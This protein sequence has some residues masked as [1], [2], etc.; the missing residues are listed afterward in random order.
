ACAALASPPR[1]AEVGAW[2]RAPH[3]SADPA[4]ID[5][6]DPLAAIVYTSGTTGRPKGA[7]LP[8][9]AFA[10]SAAASRAQLGVRAGDRW[11]ACLPLFHVGGLAVL[12]RSAADGVAVELHERFDAAA[13]ASRLASGEVQWASLVPAMLARVLAADTREASPAL[14]GILVGGAAA[15]EPLLE[16]AAKRGFPI[17]PTYGLTE[18]ASQVATRP[19]GAPGRG[20]VPLPATQVAIADDG[21]ILVA[22][23]TVMRG[24]WRQPG[25]TERALRGGW[26]HTG[27]VGR[28]DERGA[29]HVLARRTDLIVSGGENVYPAEVEAVLAEHPSVREVAVAGV[30]DAEFGARPAA[31]IVAA[32]PLDADGLR[33]FCRARLAGYKVPVAFHRVAALPRGASGKVLRDRLR[34][35]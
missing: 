29:L 27:D 1:R 4:R 17:A 25:A 5:D 2:L 13:V 31:W 3:A 24:Y 26:L 18:A 33:A 8:A 7:M 10:A 34:A 14:R 15:P 12:A 23:P 9:R 11:L 32:A 20:L 16:A 35:R 22:G 6:A 28:L 19:P 30:P 21:E